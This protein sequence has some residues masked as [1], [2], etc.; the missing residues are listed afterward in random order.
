[1]LLTELFNK[2]LTL[3]FIFW[4]W[5]PL[6]H[7]QLCMLPETL[8]TV[9]M[10]YL[11]LQELW[12]IGTW[13]WER[14]GSLNP[15]LCFYTQP[16]HIIV[17]FINGST[18]VLQVTK[19]IWLYFCCKGIPDVILLTGAFWWKFRTDSFS[20]LIY[21]WINEISFCFSTLSQSSKWSA[22]IDVG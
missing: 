9:C 2:I 20:T 19:G 14:P 15:S 4:L 13:D 16:W 17:L 8:P 3:G 1:M 11:G 22:S 18:S 12:F 5:L 21:C 7:K 6:S 10:S